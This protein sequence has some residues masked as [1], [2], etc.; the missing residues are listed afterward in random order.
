M[1]RPRLT[2]KD[3]EE[4]QKK[5][6]EGMAVFKQAEE[7][8]ERDKSRAAELGD[9]MESIALCAK[10]VDLLRAAKRRDPF[11]VSIYITFLFIIRRLI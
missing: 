7:A 8:C 5:F 10:A 3:L 9:F 6:E 1:A 2:R 11:H 4:R